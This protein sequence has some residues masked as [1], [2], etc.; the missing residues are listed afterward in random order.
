MVSQAIALRRAYFRRPLISLP[1]YI[2]SPLSHALL[3]PPV[4]T[5]CVTFC[6][7]THTHTPLP[8][9][10]L[11]YTPCPQTTQQHATREDKHFL[12]VVKVPGSQQ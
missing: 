1:S 3:I 12:V 9:S 2:S 4:Y 8:L 11:N 5:L 7:D 10:A 6:L